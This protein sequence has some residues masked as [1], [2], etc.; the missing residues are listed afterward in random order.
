MGRVDSKRRQRGKFNTLPGYKLKHKSKLTLML[1]RWA[2][3]AGR[4]S[5]LFGEASGSDIKMG[6]AQ[7]DGCG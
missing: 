1:Q 6:H 2:Q 5:A 4:K 3:V 7:M